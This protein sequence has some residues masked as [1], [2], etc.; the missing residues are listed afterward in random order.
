MY[1][2]LDRCVMPAL[3]SCSSRPCHSDDTGIL[4]KNKS[5]SLSV[6]YN[7]YKECTFGPRASKRF[8][9]WSV[10]PPDENPTWMSSSS[11]FPIEINGLES[12]STCQTLCSINVEPSGKLSAIVPM[13]MIAQYCELPTRNESE[14]RA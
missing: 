10:H 8:P 9:L 11:N 13:P 7:G 3:R 5:A 4:T 14:C 2:T 12:S 1:P 6:T